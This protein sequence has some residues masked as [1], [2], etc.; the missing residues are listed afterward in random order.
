[1]TV[2]GATTLQKLQSIQALRGVAAFLV[3]LFHCAEIQRAGLGPERQAEIELLSGFW[4]RGYAG[5]DLF[6]VISGFVM[7]Y[8]TQSYGAKDIGRFLYKRAA[9]IYPVWWIFASVMALYVYVSYGQLGSPQY[10]GPEEDGLYFLKSLLLIPQEHVPVLSVG[11][12]LI[13][14]VYFYLIFALTLFLPKRVLPIFL[15]VWAG[16]TVVGFANGLARPMVDGVPSLF[17]SLLTLEFIAGALLAWVIL[18]R[19]VPFAR[20]ILGFGIVSFIAALVFYTDRSNDLTLWG[21]VFVYTLP[22][23]A[24]LAGLVSLE[25]A[26]KI[27][28]NRWL[29]RLGDWSYAL[30]L[31]HILVILT[32]KRVFLYLEDDLPESLRFQAV[33]WI[34]NAVF[35]CVTIIVCLIVAALS[36][37]FIEQPLLRGTRKVF[38]SP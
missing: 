8:V 32:M 23:L 16:L 4:D 20:V 17:A 1:M 10:V 2:S 12:T 24:L 25:K 36:Y 34:D 14:E 13:H 6:F 11:W 7:V 22:C 38:G 3:M 27:K 28:I 35:W 18:R 21:R 15:F 19:D 31:S 29:S 30:Y 9:R 33:G 26:R 37:R 5:V